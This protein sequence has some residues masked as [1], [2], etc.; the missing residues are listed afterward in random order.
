MPEVLYCELC[1]S[2]IV[3]KSYKVSVEGVSLTVCEKCYRKQS[4]KAKEKAMPV[5]NRA[6]HALKETSSRNVKQKAKKEIELEVVDDY[7][8]RIKEARE[9]MGLSLLVLS[10]KVM[11]K[12][13]V[14][15]RVEQG[16]LRPSIDLA[17]RL[18]KALG[19]KLLEPVVDEGSSKM[20]A[21]IEDETEVTLGDIVNIRKKG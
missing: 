18:E 17:R 11:E 9:R 7:S 19:I 10:Q 12:E 15:K 13:T 20:S 4:A 14:L 8:T 21:E 3:G 6:Q 1:G 2:P 16:R 5:E